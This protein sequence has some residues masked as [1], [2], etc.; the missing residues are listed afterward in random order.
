VQ[1]YIPVAFVVRLLC[2]QL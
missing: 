1:S 2:I